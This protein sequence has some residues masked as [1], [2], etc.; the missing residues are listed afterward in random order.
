MQSRIN[1]QKTCL[2]WMAGIF[3]GVVVLVRLR[4]LGV[5]L[6]RD[7]GEYAYMAQQLLQ[8]VLPYT[9]AHSMKFPGIYFVYAGV[10]A[11][12]GQ[13][14]VA[15]HLSLLFVN[16]ATGLLLFFLGR[17]L[18]SGS[19]G[20]AAGVS[21]LVLTLSPA[22]QGFWANSEHFVLVPALGGIL[23]MRL[24]QD[25]PARFFFSGLLLGCA[26]LIKQNAVFFFLFGMIYLG[27]RVVTQFQPIKKPFLNIGLFAAGGMAPVLLSALLYWITG[28]FSDFWFCTFQYASEYVSMVSPGQGL[29]NFKYVFGQIL[30]SNFPILLLS[31]LG[32]ASASWRMRTKREYIFLIGFFVCSLLA[33]TPGFHFRKHYFLLMMPALSLLAGAG[34]DS[35]TSRLSSTGLK[36]VI[37][38]GIL[39]LALGLPV[40][41][42]KDF[43]FN[44][45]V[46][47]ATRLVYDVNPFP[48]SLEI[49]KY[50]RDHSQKDD[51]IAVFGSE[52]QI[53]FYSHRKSATR[54]IYMYPLME[55]HAYARHMQAEMIREIEESRPGFI[56]VVNIAL[57]WLFQPGFPTLLTGWARG[58]VD[59]GYE[60]SGVVDILSNEKTVY[61]WGE[62]ARSYIP[63]STHHL[64]IYKRRT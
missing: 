60:I 31:L 40:W 4:L 49:A 57:S 37:P 64:L 56:V 16:L 34:F 33:I 50:I 2:L 19:A 21:F 63:R 35:L 6:E 28:N 18:L 24:A 36:T 42:Q 62:Q 20:I 7:E 45:P 38:V 11:I 47:E 55:K 41:L 25:Q 23:L 61:K 48:E 26:L 46:T 10:L 53:Y 27:S 1:Q 8:G 29:E 39:T 58:Y 44:L 9:E 59:S 52:P 5:P 30:E 54:H 43:F 14:P 12:F 13:N 15:I 51:K 17:N 22:L 32:L 3:L